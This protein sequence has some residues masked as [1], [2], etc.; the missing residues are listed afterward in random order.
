MAL[1]LMAPTLHPTFI[2]PPAR[3]TSVTSSLSS[4]TST[5]YA[6][7]P[8]PS[9]VSLEVTDPRTF[10]A[11]ESNSA[12][13]TIARLIRAA[14]LASPER[15][16]TLDQ[17]PKLISEHYKDVKR[18][19]RLKGSVRQR[20]SCTPWFQLRDRPEWKIGKGQ[21]WTYV[22]ELDES[23]W[24]W[25]GGNRSRRGLESDHCSRQSFTRMDQDS[26]ASLPLND[27][28]I[29]DIST[30]C[31]ELDR[32]FILYHRSISHE[33]HNSNPVIPIAPTSPHQTLS[34]IAACEGLLMPLASPILPTMTQMMVDHSGRSGFG[35]KFSRIRHLLRDL[36]ARQT[37]CV[38]NKN[39]G[40]DVGFGGGES[41]NGCALGAAAI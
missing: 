18:F 21:Y 14:L 3:A 31:I 28:A 29:S 9:C 4:P 10:E 1:D 35:G 19:K 41:G 36:R 17:I 37:P 24:L 2:F 27:P 26:P 11:L 34:P 16:A 6:T 12:K 22:E 7:S 20:L 33:N 40:C 39:S 8:S 5:C 13:P 15:K 25:V 38:G 32:S 23:I 30:A